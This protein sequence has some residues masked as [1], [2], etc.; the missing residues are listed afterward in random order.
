MSMYIQYLK[1]IS[2]FKYVSEVVG[3]WEV[4]VGDQPVGIKVWKQ[5]DGT[6]RS[7]SSHL[8]KGTKQ[9]GPYRPSRNTGKSI[10]EALDVA[11][12]QITMFYD[13]DDDG[14]KWIPNEFY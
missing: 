3:E 7:D 4:W 6:F 2:L 8:Y 14:A 11:I 5:E 1:K 9:A 13:P 12:L 10:E